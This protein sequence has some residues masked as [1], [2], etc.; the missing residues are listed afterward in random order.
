MLY[1]ILPVL[2]G[3][4]IVLA[5]IIN[6]NLGKRIGNKQGTFFNFLT[7]LFFSGI[8]LLLF[9]NQMNLPYEPLEF[10]ESFILLGGLIGVICMVIT[11]YINPKMSS[12][13]LTLIVFMGQLFTGL[14]VDYV[15]M[16]QLSMGKFIGGLLVFAGF[17]YNSMVDKKKATD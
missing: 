17:A 15:T 13:S 16:H 12:L 9:K 6:S 5:R 11:N 14:M 3:I 8:L 7:G 10:N 2:A 1:I 4:T